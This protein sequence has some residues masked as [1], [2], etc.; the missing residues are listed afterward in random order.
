[1]SPA[2]LRDFELDEKE[3]FENYVQKLAAEELDEG[4]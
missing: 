4:E 2:E 3:K 1:M